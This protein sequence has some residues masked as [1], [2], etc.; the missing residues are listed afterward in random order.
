MDGFSGCEGMGLGE[1]EFVMK[2]VEVGE[3][4]VW[5]TFEWARYGVKE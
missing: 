1:M 4:N 5:F 2:G 3:M